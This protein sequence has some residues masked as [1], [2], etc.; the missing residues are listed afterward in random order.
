MA[1]IEAKIEYGKLK[2][3]VQAMSKQYS[4]KVGLL[5]STPG[6]NGLKGSDSISENMDL[7]GIGAVQE[8]GAAINVTEK[9]RAFLRHEFGI[10]LKK[11]TTQIVIP[12][13]SW[14]EMP[15]TKDNGKGLRKKLFAKYGNG[16]TADDI[17][18]HITETGDIM[19][20]AVLI[21]AA[22]IEQIQDAFDTEGFG[23]WEPNSPVTIAKKGSAKPLVDK[24][25]LRGAIAFEVEKNG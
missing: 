16:V 14:L 5:A 6:E 25:R 2:K 18:E 12:T 22:A 4:V 15:L 23:E 20:L 3:L 11:T 1:E 24:G 7:A 19:S 9:M 17:L 21:G 13:R 10:N 8:F